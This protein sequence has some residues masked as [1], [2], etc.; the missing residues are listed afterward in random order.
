[1][2]GSD[3]EVACFLSFCCGQVGLGVVVVGISRAHVCVQLEG[4]DGQV[5]DQLFHGLVEL[6]LAGVPL[7]MG[8][9]LGD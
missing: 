2:Q 4:F 1:M 6:E 8:Q 9:V 5:V 3:G 7:E